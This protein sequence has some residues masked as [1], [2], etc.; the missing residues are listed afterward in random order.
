MVGRKPRC[1]SDSE[2]QKAAPRPVR[3]EEVLLNTALLVPPIAWS[4]HLALTYGLVYPAQDWQSKSALH[5]VTLASFALSMGS[6]AVGAWAFR[7]Q[8]RGRVE[9]ARRA[10]QRFL[11]LAACLSGIFFCLATLAQSVPLLMLPLGAGP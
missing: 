5:A 1:L 7:P 6:V 10:R 2:Q 9:A 11:A 4:I 3:Y 8:R